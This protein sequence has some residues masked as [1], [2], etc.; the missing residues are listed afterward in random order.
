[1][2]SRIPALLGALLL[3]STAAV[4]AEA[5][6]SQMHL[7][8]RISYHFDAEVIGLGAQFSVP[9]GQHL[10][11]YPS[12]DVFLVDAGSA[13]DLNVDLKL[14][15]SEASFRWLYLGGGLNVARRS[16]GAFEDTRAGLNRFAGIESLR[17]RVHPF[18]EL[19]LVA[20]DNTTVRA[21]FGLNLTL[22]AH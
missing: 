18:G 15:I 19:R 13:A 14:R 17:G 8:P 12:F 10:E 3:A 7:G 6:T 20:N 5:Q 1:M 2:K 21:A 22:H 4:T 16:V 11:F 9:M